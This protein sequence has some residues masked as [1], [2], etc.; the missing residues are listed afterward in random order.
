MSEAWEV[1]PLEQWGET[2]DWVIV[3]ESAAADP[4]VTLDGSDV[5][6]LLARLAGWDAT[7]MYCSDRY[8]VVMRA[9]AR[10]AS[11]ALEAAV[12]G[13]AAAA[14][15]V[16]GVGGPA[17]SV[18]RAEVLKAEEFEASFADSREVVERRNN[19]YPGLASEELYLATRSLLW[20]STPDEIAAVLARFVTAAGGAVRVG[21]QRHLP[22]LVSIDF[23]FRNGESISAVAGTNSAAGLLLEES[24]PS[25]VEDAGRVL[26]ARRPTH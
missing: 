13:H 16:G 3:L 8:A 5:E 12:E 2:G 19:R 4:G 25:L 26:D 7:A 10:T 22:G 6:H 15:A 21:P 9:T 18:V 23:S 11:D 1:V 17:F 14:R 20:S 24:L